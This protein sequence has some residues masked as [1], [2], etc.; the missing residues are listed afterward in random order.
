V[1]KDEVLTLIRAMLFVMLV[2]ALIFSAGKPA[3]ANLD[4]EAGA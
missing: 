1:E 2:F 4:A 3:H